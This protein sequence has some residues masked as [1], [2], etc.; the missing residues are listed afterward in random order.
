MARATEVQGTQVRHKVAFEAVP[1]SKLPAELLG[2]LGSRRV[3]DVAIIPKGARSLTIYDVIE[4]MVIVPEPKA[5]GSI[6]RTIYSEPVNAET[7]YVVHT[8]EEADKM[9]ARGFLDVEVNRNQRGRVWVFTGDA[10][11]AAEQKAA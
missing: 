10:Q 5:F 4:L 9:R 7:F 1:G 8:L 2:F 3:Q 6:K 11:R